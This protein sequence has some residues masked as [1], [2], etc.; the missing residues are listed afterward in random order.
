MMASAV[1]AVLTARTGLVAS[2]W[3]EAIR[4]AAA[5]LVEAGAITPAYVDC[6]I[7][8]VEDAGPYMVIAPGI[9]LAHAR[10]TDGARSLALSVG[11]FDQP[12]EF[13]HPQNDPVRLVFV[14]A[15][16]DNDQHVLLLKGL[17]GALLRGLAEKLL[18]AADDAAAL[19]LLEEEIE[20]DD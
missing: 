10:P 14:F 11:R 19:R 3:R 17:A 16:P 4:V 8:M 5:P 6:A 7:A 20:V 1:R 12:I 15:S 18:A 9:A 2:D 13:G